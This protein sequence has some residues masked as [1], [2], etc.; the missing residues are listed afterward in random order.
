MKYEIINAKLERYT[1][2]AALKTV[3]E[4]G[5]FTHSYRLHLISIGV[6]WTVRALRF[7]SGDSILKLLAIVIGVL[8]SIVKTVS[9]GKQENY[10][11]YFTKVS[12]LKST[13]KLLIDNE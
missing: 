5:F 10:E 13:D 4:I 6:K 7:L 8:V 1:G 2:K 12:E 9:Q 3:H 11:L